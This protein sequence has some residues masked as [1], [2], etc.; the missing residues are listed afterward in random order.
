M[1][2]FPAAD[3]FVFEG[4]RLDRRAGGLFRADEGG[5]LAPVAIGSRAL[6]R[7]LLLV[8]RHG[9]LVSKD[10]IMT[11]IWPGM[12][13]AESNLPAHIWA[14]RKVLDRGRANGSCIQTVARRGYRFVAAVTRTPA[15]ARPAS[16]WISPAVA[17]RQ[18]MLAP[19]LSLAVLPFA[20]FSDSSDQQHLSDRITEDLTTDLS[21]FNNM[22]VVS[23]TTAL[24]YR[25]KP[26]DAKQIGRELDV[27]YVLEG[28][29]QRFSDRIR[30]NAHLIDARADT[31][32]WAQRFDCDA[33]A[34]SALQDE[35]R[36]RSTVALYQALIDAEAARPSER[37]VTLDYVVR[38]RVANLRA[39]GRDCY[40]GSICLFERALAIDPHSPEAQAW[41]AETLAYRAFEGIAEAAAADIARAKGLA[42]Q[43][44]A[45]S[46]RSAF[47]HVAQWRVL[48][49]QAGSRRR[50]PNARRRMR[51]IPACRITT[52]IWVLADYGPARSTTRSRLPNAR[53]PSVRAIPTGPIG[54]SPSG[55]CI[56]SIEHQRGDRVVR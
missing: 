15:Q 48:C 1:D 51:S 54:I 37:P 49:A 27:R 31:H 28:S 14:L 3:V 4:F 41:L 46:P 53:W 45:A 10:E 39:L 11:V 47:A 17:T 36:K 50:S 38:G 43:A 20:N 7:L 21:R 32:L 6:D 24:T 55:R 56:Y 12:T 44:L 22:R 2:A 29:A 8:C 40:A 13:V 34:P 35:I 30:V 26:V 33:D 9:D 42:A 25:N 16:P 52:A 5:V 18:P 23:R 19:P